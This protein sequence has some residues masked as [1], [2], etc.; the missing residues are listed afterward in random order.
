MSLEVERFKNTLREHAQTQGFDIALWDDF[1]G[2]FAHDKDM[3][4][5]WFGYDGPCPPWNDE[6]AHHY[7]FTVRAL[8]VPT[9]G[10]TG[11]F[12]LGDVERAMEQE[13]VKVSLTNLRSFPCVR[14]KEKSGELKLVGSFF[15]ISDG[16]LHTLD[17]TT[18]EFS[19]VT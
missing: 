12:T 6:L 10:L 17:E 11:A 8:D 13:G 15:A 2:W 16:V 3:S 1:S 18:G 19:P 14:A 5:T 7:E 9:L 4:G